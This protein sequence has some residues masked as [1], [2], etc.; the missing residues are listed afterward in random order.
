ME[1]VASV[2]LLAAGVAAEETGT[3]P[4]ALRLYE[5]RRPRLRTRAIHGVAVTL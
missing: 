5:V 1:D 2:L 3:H 4:W